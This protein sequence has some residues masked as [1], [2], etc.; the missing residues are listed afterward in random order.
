MNRALLLIL[1]LGIFFGSP[2]WIIIAIGCYI[3]YFAYEWWLKRVQTAVETQMDFEPSKINVDQEGKMRIRLRNNSI[4]PIHVIVSFEADLPIE[5]KQAYKSQDPQRIKNTYSIHFLLPPKGSVEKQLEVSARHRGLYWLDNVRLQIRDPL[6]LTHL[7]LDLNIIPQLMVFPKPFF[8]QE[9]ARIMHEPMGDVLSQERLL[10]EDQAFYIGSRN[11]QTGDPFKRLDWKA[12]ARRQSLQTKLYDYT[13]HGK[14]YFV[15]DPPVL[16]KD[17]EEKKAILEMWI[18]S[19]STLI[20]FCRKQGIVYRV[21]INSSFRISKKF[22]ETPWGSNR[23]HYQSILELLARLKVNKWISFPLLLHQ[24]E[25]EGHLGSGV[26]VLKQDWKEEDRL[27]LHR[28]A[29]KGYRVWIVQLSE[30]GSTLQPL[31]NV[32]GREE[33]AN[34]RS[35]S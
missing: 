16:L 32:A 34:G 4:L 35:I 14:V 23:K 9:M 26:V 33:N 12:T 11:Y 20:S 25:R 2:K 19:L 1:F 8:V 6:G 7:E 15:M 28:L 10:Q 24:I 30:H 17:D 18:G 22:S 5:I 3:I 27:A 13:V 21:L 29:R 31:A